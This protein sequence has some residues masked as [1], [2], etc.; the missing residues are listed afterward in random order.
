[1]SGYV[2]EDLIP[3]YTGKFVIQSHHATNWHFDLR[4]SFPVKS[5]SKALADYS[6]KRPHK[7]VEPSEAAPDKPGLV[8]RSWA[9]PKHKLPT[10]KPLLATETEDHDFSY[11]TFQGTIPEGQYGAGTVEIFDKGTYK[12]EDVDYDKKY[13]FTLKGRKVHGTY[14]L[15][16]T[17]GK[18]FL[19]IKTKEQKKACISEHIRR[20]ASAIDYVRP[21]MEPHIWDLAKQPP[22]LNPAVKTH[23]LKTFKDTLIE[24]GFP[25]PLKWVTHLYLSGSATSYNYQEDGDLDIDV[26]VDQIQE[27]QFNKIQSILDTNCRKIEVPGTH[28]TYSF[29]LLKPEDFPAADGVYDIFENRWVHGPYKIPENF[30]PDETFARQKIIA[31]DIMKKIEELLLGAEIIVKELE[32]IDQYIKLHGKLSGKKI[33]HLRNLF[34][35]CFQLYKWRKYLWDMQEAAKDRIN[36][37]YPAFDYSIDWDEKYI[38]FKYI[39]RQGLH[40]PIQMLYYRLGKGNPYIQVIRNSLPKDSVGRFFQ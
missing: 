25:D 34:E 7:G 3:G 23:L 40:E 35:I 18:S 22:L 12:L 36:P 29:M 8:L 1:M 15:I 39:A 28:L 20:V 21:T 10:N 6:E 32:K 27:D 4:L 38:I 13:V 17:S 33:I 30:D 2:K 16:K 11:R 31:L 24:N 5:V 14:A 37:T 26:L 19:W 9:I